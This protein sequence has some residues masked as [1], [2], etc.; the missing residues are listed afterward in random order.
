MEQALGLHEPFPALEHGVRRGAEEDNAE[1]LGRQLGAVLLDHGRQDRLSVEP[2]DGHRDEQEE[3]EVDHALQLQPH[4]R[5]VAAAVGLGTERV[6]R[7]GETLNGRV[8]G[9][10]GGHG[11]ERDGAELEGAEAADGEDGGDVERVLEQEGDD[12]G[13]RVDGDGLGLALPGG[14]DLAGSDGS[15]PLL[16]EVLGVLASGALTAV[17]DAAVT[18]GAAVSETAFTEQRF[19]LGPYSWRRRGDDDLNR[20]VGAF[21]IR[22]PSRDLGAEESLI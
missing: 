4:E 3:Q 12:E 10:A 22:Y 13:A 5:L 7:G 16:V 9:D 19:S 6:Q 15:F 11:G 17:V 14:L 20:T 2:D 18:V 1:I 8:A 21:F